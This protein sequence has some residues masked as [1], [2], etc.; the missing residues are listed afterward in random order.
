MVEMLQFHAFE[1]LVFLDNAADQES[2]KANFNAVNT[3]LHLTLLSPTLSAPP[4]S[5]LK[6]SICGGDYFCS[7]AVENC[8]K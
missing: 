4:G 6:Q 1:T 2:A 8:A 7:S 5:P 3:P